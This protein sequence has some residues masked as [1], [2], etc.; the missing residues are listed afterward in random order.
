MKTFSLWYYMTNERFTGDTATVCQSAGTRSM[1]RRAWL[2]EPSQEPPRLDSSF[3]CNTFARSFR[4]YDNRCEN[5]DNFALMIIKRRWYE[6]ED[7][8][9]FFNGK[10]RTSSTERRRSDQ[11]DGRV[12]PRTRQDA[13]A[14][15]AVWAR[16]L[17]RQQIDFKRSRERN[18]PKSRLAMRSVFRQIW[19]ISKQ[20]NFNFF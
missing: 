5:Y 13:A 19:Q 2:E 9:F 10:K 1:R 6:R 17:P 15:D 16:F 12:V 14:N 3:W 8:R 11:V 18:D 20:L 7:I 4:I